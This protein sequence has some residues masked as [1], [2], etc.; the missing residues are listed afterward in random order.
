MSQ[1]LMKFDVEF[2]D[3][4]HYQEKPIYNVQ[5]LKEEQVMVKLLKRV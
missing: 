5:V 2:V 3:K 4:A 1:I